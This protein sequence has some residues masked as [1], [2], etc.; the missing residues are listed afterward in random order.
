MIVTTEIYK[1]Q[2][3]RCV[4]SEPYTR[5]RDGSPTVLKVWESECTDCGVSF[6]FKTPSRKS[7]FEPNRRCDEHKK[8]TGGVS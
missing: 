3:Y 4:G 2:I 1:G 8:R 7:K 5:Q 6:I